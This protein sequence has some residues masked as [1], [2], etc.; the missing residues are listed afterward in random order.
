[1]PLAA[2][3]LGVLALILFF[4]PFIAQILG[5]LAIIFGII[6][7]VGAKKKGG[8]GFGMGI[9]GLITGGIGMFLSIAIVAALLLPAI[10]NA[11]GMAQRLESSSNMKQIVL[12]EMI[13]RDEE[14]APSPDFKTLAA[15]QQLSDKLFQSPFAPG[16]MDSYTMLPTDGSLGS[17]HPNYCRRPPRLRK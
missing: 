6:A 17:R 8:K 10:T 11:R 15:H 9:A 16:R 12:H 5:L 14:G 13:Y 3:I 4:V 2:L 1:M 7:M